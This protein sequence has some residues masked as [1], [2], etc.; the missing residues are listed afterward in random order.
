MP[1]EKMPCTKCQTAMRLVTRE[2]RI[3]VA[4]V[5]FLVTMP[6]WE[7]PMDESWIVP[8]A[9]HQE[10][11][12]QALR[13]IATQGP[14]TGLTLKFLRGSLKMKATELAELVDTAP[15]TLSRWET[16]A[17]PVNPLVWVAVAAMALDK[18]DGRATTQKQ[19]RA[20][21]EPRGSEQAISFTVGSFPK[22]A[23]VELAPGER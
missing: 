5:E 4:G 23:T 1:T 8:V 20:A 17:K 12:R 22:S 19:L 9:V 14:A 21:R 3:P 11:D 13:T 10:F 15:E 16:G 2:K 18:L 7:C 6:V